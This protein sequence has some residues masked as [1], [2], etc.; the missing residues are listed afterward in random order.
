MRT[1]SSLLVLLSLVAC[2]TTPAST[3]DAGTDGGGDDA[4]NDA[5]RSDGGPDAFT[6]DAN[7]SDA[8]MPRTDYGSA[9][10]YPVGNVRVIM[11][12]RTGARM[13]PVEIWYPAAES[14]RAAAAT[15]QSM[16]AFEGGT[17]HESALAALVT[18]APA[19]CAR[20]QSHSAAAPAAATPTAAWPAVVFSHCF[21]CMRFDLAEVA[22]RLASHG[23][24]V[25][26]P[27]HLGNTYWDAMQAP[28][29]NTYLAVRASDVSSVLDR[30]LD[31][32]ATEVPADLRG[33]IDG[34]HVGVMGHS[35]GAL[36]T[37]AVVLS[38]TRFIA[39]LAFAA[40]ISALGAHASDVHV[41]YAF[42]L[43]GE[44]NSIGTAGNAVLRSD[45]AHVSGPAW[46]V[47]VAE[48]GHWSFSD[49]AGM[50]T[51]WNAGCGMGMRQQVPHAPFTYVDNA[52]ARELAS[53]VAAAFFASTLLG[54]P[55]A[56]NVL[57]ALD[58]P[59]FVSM[60]P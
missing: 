58:A 52:Q 19:T 16:T 10:A 44:D 23:I 14:A 48:A 54:D 38:D 20:T 6:R 24:V 50:T 25:A 22:E 40:P 41:P 9:G 15:G 28:I 51:P 13:L 18:S 42:V 47:E 45:F 35:Y 60:H 53:D 32:T 30:L 49:I 26:A 59:A 34:A 3:P 5:A 12:D 37:G 1:S 43:A 8:G 21:G 57:S 33:H 56:V 2:T 17:A 27:D 11:T 7:F 46:L 39:A 36:T 55:A 29:D 4:G 31:A